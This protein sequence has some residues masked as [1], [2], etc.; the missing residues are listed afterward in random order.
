[1]NLNT[2]FNLTQTI[3]ALQKRGYSRT[4]KLENEKLKCHQNNKRY[5]QHDLQIVEYHRFEIDDNHPEASIIFALV[6]NDGEQGYVISSE[7]NMLS[8]KLLQFMDKVKIQ[9][10]QVSQTSNT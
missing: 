6:S 8:K 2:Y 3:K 9:L 1:M 10:R 7:K 4:F 5:A